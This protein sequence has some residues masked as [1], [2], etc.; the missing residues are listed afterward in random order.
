MAHV[1]LP[2]EDGFVVATATSGQIDFS[3]DFVAWEKADLTIKQNG[4]ALAA[5]AWSV[6]FNS[7]TDGGNDGG[8][9]TLNSGATAG[10]RVEIIRDVNA[11]RT[12]DFTA[13]TLSFSAINTE[14]DKSVA[15]ERDLRRDVDRALVFPIDE[16]GQEIGDA[17]DR[18]NKTLAFDSLGNISLLASDNTVIVASN[19]DAVNSVAADLDGD[20][21]IG[22]VAA[23]LDGDDTIGAAASLI[24]AGSPGFLAVQGAGSAAVRSFSGAS[25]K[26]TVSNGAGGGNVVIDLA[27]AYDRGAANGVATLDA[28]GLLPADQLPPLSITSVKTYADITA[29]D[30]DTANR[31]EGDVAVVTDA[32]SGLTRSFILDSTAAWRELTSPGDVFSVAGKTGAVSL[33]KA[34]VGLGDVD[35]TPDADKPV[36]DATQAALDLKL[37]AASYTAADV[38]AKVAAASDSNVFTDAEKTK[39]GGVA[40]GANVTPQSVLDYAAVIALPDAAPGSASFLRHN[41][42][43]TTTY[44]TLSSLGGGDVVAANAGSEY[45][46]NAS[47]FRDNVGLGASDSVTFGKLLAGNGSAEN[48]GYQAEIVSGGNVVLK[49]QAGASNTAFLGFGTPTSALDT[50]V[51]LNNN[52]GEFRIRHGAINQVQFYDDG[53]GLDMMSGGYVQPGRRT[54]VNLPAA[55]TANRGAIQYDTTRGELVRSDG[56]NWLPIATGQYI[57]ATTTDLT[58]ITSPAAD[59][60]CF[61][62]GAAFVFND[63]D[64]ST[65]VGYETSGRHGVYFPPDSD[66]TGASGAWVREAFLRWGCLCPDWFLL[67][68]DTSDDDAMQAAI[69]FIDAEGASGAYSGNGRQIQ[70]RSRRYYF[71][72]GWSVPNTADGVTILGGLGKTTVFATDQDIVLGMIGPDYSGGGDTAGSNGLANFTVHGVV[73]RDEDATGTAVALQ[74]NRVGGA[75]LFD[76]LFVDFYVSLDGYR[77][78]GG[79]YIHQC[80]FRLSQRTSTNK[81]KAF[82]RLQ[83]VY[84]S[85][86]SYT[87]GGGIYVTDCEMLGNFSD[88]AALEYAYYVRSVDGL[89]I[90]GGHVNAYD[91]FFC[92]DPD[93][94]N[95]NNT[96]IDIT[97]DDMYIDGNHLSSTVMFLLTGTVD[98]NSNGGSYGQ[99]HIRNIRG[100][101]V[102]ASQFFFLRVTA[103]NGWDKLRDISVKDCQ[104]SGF[105]NTA[106]SVGGADAGY[107]ECEDFEL[108]R[109]GFH[110]N[111]ADGAISYPAFNIE[112]KSA[113]ID[114]NIFGADQTACNFIGRLNVSGGA[115]NGGSISNN[116]ARRS[117]AVRPEQIFVV[118]NDPGASVDVLNN[119]LPGGEGLTFKQSYRR[120]ETDGDAIIFWRGDLPSANSLTTVRAVASAA[121]TDTA[122]HYVDWE[123]RKAFHVN[124]SGTINERGA[125]TI[126]DNDSFGSV[127]QP[128]AIVRLNGTA[129]SNGMSVSLGDVITNGGRA[130]LVINAGDG[131]ITDATGPTSTSG[132]EVVDDVRLL[133][134]GTPNSDRIVVVGT[135]FA[136]TAMEWTVDVEILQSR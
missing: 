44:V 37:D 128:F 73:F 99:I 52:T 105:S 123:I 11:V 120:S 136:G 32:G 25:G 91:T 133:Y 6:T 85:T 135:G 27:A 90:K 9:V 97:L 126:S 21:D 104:I 58:A 68:T 67:G 34:D 119:R 94:S 29:R 87:P 48:S 125:R 66:T 93:G 95:Q 42:D 53:R 83:G 30:A 28:N 63:A 103:A 113:I 59:E 7:G 98:A 43:G 79:S 36:S 89:W 55:A 112:A 116:D 74:L 107:V 72:S 106:V 23:D 101:G 54:T 88:T 16:A 8:T 35:N 24:A 80:D 92:T 75:H 121:S 2:D 17:S 38:R 64:L 4:V 78:G 118:T 114:D 77:F 82:I 100:R 127:D 5:S 124:N 76:C 109:C 33:V 18:A 19:I 20:N 31:Q 117:N 131:T 51:S 22:V 110:E 130:Y 86:N 61:V 41:A 1:T 60:V 56:S 102:T 122:N 62:G 10:D 40:A 46:A 13:G 49:L 50:A 47:D 96:I 39:L 45:T 71:S 70:C 108:R 134:L 26:V 129:Y 65:E 14:F 84:D 12:S 81:A 57:A 111:A 132:Q 115:G 3:F 15:R 69:D